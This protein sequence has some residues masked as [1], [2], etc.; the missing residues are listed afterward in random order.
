MNKRDIRSFAITFVIIAFA[1]LWVFYPLDEL[2]S[3]GHY[4]DWDDC[5]D[6][7][8][9]DWQLCE[10]Y[11]YSP[12]ATNT[13][14][15]VPPTATHTPVP[16]TATRTPVPPT[17]THT[18]V[19]NDELYDDWDDCRATETEQFCRRL[20]FKPP[21]EQ[22]PP[23]ATRTPR[24]V[25]T[26]TAVP[27]ATHTPVPPTAT[28]IH[29]DSWDDCIAVGETEE[30]CRQLGLIPIDEATPTP[31]PPTATKT[32][33]VIVQRPP[34]PA[35][36][37]FHSATETSLSFTLSRMKGT[38]HYRVGYKQVGA[39]DWTIT[40]GHS[41]PASGTIKHTVLGLTKGTSYNVAVG[42]K[43][44]GKTYNSTGYGQWSPSSTFDTRANNLP[45]RGVGNHLFALSRALGLP[46]PITAINVKVNSVTGTQRV[47][48][49]YLNTSRHEV[50]GLIPGA[51]NINFP[52][53]LE[54][55]GPRITYTEPN[56]STHSVSLS[57]AG[58]C[59]AAQA[60]L[61]RAWSQGSALIWPVSP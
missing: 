51:G 37:S 24:P 49:G 52:V 47:P 25:A 11:G 9:D 10:D 57:S 53:R 22:S 26:H 2:S 29:Y 28:P 23:T 7:N 21:W 50:S 13:P 54:L 20:G 16:P 44:D 45:T 58:T 30:L 59:I 3:D 56:G 15:P 12:P 61:C 1:A 18:P 42:Y 48:G 31:V 17:A 41:V 39:S 33:V 36:P 60:D 27:T 55:I 43:G 34:A 5:M 38:T 19:P 14:T 32:P 35:A 4:Q 8:Y 40:R 6:D 46:I